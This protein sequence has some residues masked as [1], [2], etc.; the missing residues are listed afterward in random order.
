MIE[1]WS[2]ARTKDTYPNSPGNGSAPAE[3]TPITVPLYAGYENVNTFVS[4][5]Q[6][7][8]YLY[9]INQNN[10]VYQAIYQSYDACELAQGS[11]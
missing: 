11:S 4:N 10:P 8:G 3:V 7:H 5:V 1:R 2:R 9:T 6:Q